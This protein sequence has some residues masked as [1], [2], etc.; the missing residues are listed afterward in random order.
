MTTSA[1]APAAHRRILLHPACPRRTAPDTTTTVSA[2]PVNDPP[3]QWRAASTNQFAHWITLTMTAM[4]ENSGRY[5][6]S[7]I[8]RPDAVTTDRGIAAHAPPSEP[9][10]DQGG[11]TLLTARQNLVA[12]GRTAHW[13]LQPSPPMVRR[14]RTLARC[15][16]NTWNL[17]SLVDDVELLVSELTTNALLH[18]TG[19]ISLHLEFRGHL[20]CEVGDD[21]PI[22][23]TPLHPLPG[24]ETGRGLYLVS[25]LA[26]HWGMTRTQTGKLVWFE[27]HM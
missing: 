22:L 11:G 4:S 12:P 27:L 18:A 26:T 16:L 19:L 14:A 3:K 5:Q 20:R 8:N 17:A 6:H 23:P 1:F 7:R 10:T 25:Q 9:G 15:V 13:S 21:E 2:R 24:S